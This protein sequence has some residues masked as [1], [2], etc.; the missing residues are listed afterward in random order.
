M[1]R[2]LLETIRAKVRARGYVLTAHA[3]EEMD[4]DG[5]S[6]FDVE[7]AILTGRIV[8]RQRDPRTRE[9]K[10]VIRGSSVE[11]EEQVVTVVKL[12]PLARW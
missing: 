6:I 10:Y 2:R 9:P 12:G 7:S 8:G 4:E 1:S 11:G 5:L 3:E